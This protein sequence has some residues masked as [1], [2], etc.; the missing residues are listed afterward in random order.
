MCADIFEHT[1]KASLVKLKNICIFS[2]M[3]FSEVSLRKD[4]QICLLICLGF[5]V[6]QLAVLGKTIAVSKWRENK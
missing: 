1:K 2:K 6:S 3:T 4:F 5:V